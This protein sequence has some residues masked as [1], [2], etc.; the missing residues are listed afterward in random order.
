MW[1]DPQVQLDGVDAAINNLKD[2]YQAIKKPFDTL[3][4]RD[5][6]MNDSFF[7]TGL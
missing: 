6:L 4:V 3:E 2:T 7:T 5:V 1:P